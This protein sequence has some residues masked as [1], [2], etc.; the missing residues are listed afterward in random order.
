M[1]E[2]QESSWLIRDTSNHIRGPFRQAEIV[3]MVKKGQLKGKMEI[4]RANS[5]WFSIEEKVELARFFPEFNH[6]QP[7]PEAPTQ[8]TATLTQAEIEENQVDITTFTAA[9]SKQIGR[10]HV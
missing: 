1:N 4:S 5:Y 3:A 10:A 7:V 8:M 9:P 6:G 2:N